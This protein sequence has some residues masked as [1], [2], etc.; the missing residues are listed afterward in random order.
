MDLESEAKIRDAIDHLIRETGLTV[1]V[2]AH[3]PETIAKADHVIALQQGRVAWQGPS[4]QYQTND[5][6][7]ARAAT[8]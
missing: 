6:L 8:Q 1:L 5:A 4:D 3:R 7:P 2:I